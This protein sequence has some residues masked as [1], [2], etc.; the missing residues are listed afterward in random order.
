MIEWMKKNRKELLLPF[1]CFVLGL[2]LAIARIQVQEQGTD[3][4]EDQTLSRFQ[5]KDYKNL[6]SNDQEIKQFQWT[7]EAVA[8]LK[9]RLKQSQQLGIRLETVVT[10]WGKAQKVRYTKTAQGEQTVLVLT[11]AAKQTDQGKKSVNL[12]FEEEKDQGYRLTMVDATNLLDANEKAS[13]E[14][15]ITTEKEN[16]GTELAHLI[17]KLGTPQRLV[18][19]ELLDGEEGFLA[20]YQIPGQAEVVMEL[21]KK[22]KKL[23]L[24]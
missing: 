12:W 5:P 1:L 24:V 3:T 16:K 15:E 17:N 4:K 10:E 22:G 14:K 23:V 6:V 7:I 8:N 18:W 20:T 13:S 21:K 9:V 11:Y 19:G 2:L